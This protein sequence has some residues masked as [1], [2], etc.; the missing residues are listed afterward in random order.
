MLVVSEKCFNEMDSC[1]I[2]LIVE[3]YGKSVS[4]EIG[5]AIYIKRKLHQKIQL[6]RY[7]SSH[8]T[9]AD[10]YSEAMI[11]PYIDH[12][13]YSVQE[14]VKLLKCEESFEL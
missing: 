8:F 9:N 6:I 5:Y 1:N 11:T 7:I 12:T 4:C 14:L 3:P 13:V 2:I 10:E